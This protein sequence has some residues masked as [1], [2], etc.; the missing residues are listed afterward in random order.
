MHTNFDKE[1]ISSLFIEALVSN[2]VRNIEMT[3]EWR[4][5]FNRLPKQILTISF[6]STLKF[7]DQIVKFSLQLPNISFQLVTKIWYQN[8]ITSRR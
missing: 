3:I 1:Y 8:K 7:Q 5:Y 2:I 4:K 6:V